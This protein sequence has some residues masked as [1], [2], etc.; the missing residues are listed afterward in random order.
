MPR[1]APACRPPPRCIHA[2]GLCVGLQVKSVTPV[3]ERVF[4]KAEEAETKTVGGIL[5]PTSAQKRPTQG[6]VQSAGSAK[7][8]KVRRTPDGCCLASR[9]HQHPC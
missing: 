5:L 3:G 2:A 4:V 8:V 7:A 6:T 9:V 1:N